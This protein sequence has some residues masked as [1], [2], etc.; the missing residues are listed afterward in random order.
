[1]SSTHAGRR[2][3][4]LEDDVTVSRA[5]ERT[6]QGYELDMVA[7]VADAKMRIES[8]G[9]YAAWIL[10]VR[11]PDG[12]GL[13]VLAWARLR[14]DR[15]PALVMTGVLDHVHANSAQILGAEFVFKP[16]GKAHLDSFLERATRP[17]ETPLP[18]RNAEAF[19]REHGLT[20]REG[21]IIHAIARG[22]PRADLAGQ[23]GVAESTIK[24]LV[25]R[26]LERA[27]YA[28]LDEV[29]RDL[30]KRE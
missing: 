15:T 9:S 23:L 11:V 18:S 8:G 29:L 13:D 12:S 5:L 2:L 14:G 25:H 27:G 16:Y 3:L 20:K 6:L 26:L 17:T 4:C 22:V 10:D 28:N 19:V 21:E 24:T 1:M 7:T 30:L